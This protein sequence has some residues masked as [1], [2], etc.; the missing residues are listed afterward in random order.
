MTARRGCTNCDGVV[1]RDDAA[2]TRRL[3]RRGSWVRAEIGCSAEI[4]KWRR[5]VDARFAMVRLF[6]VLKSIESAKFVVTAQRAAR[7]LQ[8]RGFPSM[9]STYY[10][11]YY[12]ARCCNGSAREIFR[13]APSA[14]PSTVSGERGGRPARFTIRKNAMKGVF[15]W[16]FTISIL[17]AVR[18]WRLD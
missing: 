17:R 18:L 16:R 3:Q 10:T 11:D 5:S 1:R 14:W 2:L 15:I 12:C 9:V 13:C 6:D 4:A 7:G 8:R